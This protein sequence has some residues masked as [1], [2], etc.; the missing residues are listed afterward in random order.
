MSF[1]LI[2]VVEKKPLPG[3][4]TLDNAQHNINIMDHE[5]QDYGNIISG[6]TAT[7]DAIR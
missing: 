7:S 6:N 5:I 4:R 2:P 3:S 1:C